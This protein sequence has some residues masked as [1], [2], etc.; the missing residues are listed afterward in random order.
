[1]YSELYLTD[2]T[3]KLDLLGANRSNNSV[4]IAV[5]KMILSRPSRESSGIFQQPYGSVVET[6]DLS[7]TGY[8]PNDVAARQQQLD[9]WLEQATN[10]FQSTAEG[11]L[12]WL[13][14]RALGETNTRYAVIY[15]G[16]IE[17]YGDIYSQP[18]SDRGICSLNDITLG[19]ERGTWLGYAPGEPVCYPLDNTYHWNSSSNAWTSMTTVTGVQSLFTTAAGTILAGNTAI[20]RSV[21]Q[22][23]GWTVPL[24]PAVANLRFWKFIQ[25][26]AGRI[27]A[28]AGMTTGAV[29]AS[30]G[31][32]FSDTD[33]ASW[34]Q[35]TNTVDF[36]G[37]AYRASDDTIIFGGDGEVR[38]IRAGGA[39]TVMSTAPTG[40]LKALEV[41]ASNDTVLGDDY[42][43]WYIPAAELSVYSGLVESVNSTDV[44]GPYLV[45]IKVKDYAIVGSATNLMISRDGGKT[46]FIYWRDWG[47]DSLSVLRNG[48]VLA[49]RAGTANVFQSFD[50]AMSWKLLS[51]LAAST[52]R[53]FCELPNQ[54]LFAGAGNA[55]Y[56]RISTQLT[57][58]YGVIEP[59]CDSKVLFSNHR[60][61]A[62]WTHILINDSSAGTF[63]TVTPDI[64]N[65]NVENQSD[66]LCFPASVGTNDAMYIGISTSVQDAGP[67]SNVYLELTE[68]N[69]TLTLAVEY[70]NGSAWT[71]LVDNSS[72]RDNTRSLKRS[73]VI[74]IKLA[75]SEQMATIAIN[76]I[77]AWWI[78]IRVTALG[79]LP[80]QLPK[81]RNVYIVQKPY[82]EMQNIPGDIPALARL[83]VKNESYSANFMGSEVVRFIAGL[84]SVDR[85]DNFTSI[86]NFS[87]I[88]NPPGIS[89]SAGVSSSFQTN[90][91][92]AAAGEFLR[93]NTSGSSAPITIG[94]LNFDA[95]MSDEYA[96]VYQVYIRLAKSGGDPDP[97]GTNCKIRLSVQS[98]SSTNVVDPGKKTEE[99]IVTN[100][101]PGLFGQY[102]SVYY[103]GKINIK[104]DR[105]MGN[106]DSGFGS[107]ILVQAI[108]VPG[109]STNYIVDLYDIILVPADEWIGFFYG[110]DW[111]ESSVYGD[112]YLDV[113]SAKLPKRTIRSMVRKI[114]TDLVC[115]SWTSDSSGIFALQPG[116][117][118][119]RLWM[120]S[121]ADHPYVFSAKLEYNPRWL[122][123]RGSD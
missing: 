15:G 34:T 27:W 32:Y 4:G 100:G 11:N 6:Y 36:F 41:I 95:D 71:A 85:G 66:A 47:I 49:G 23:V 52:V 22:G 115:S 118:K 121:L 80:A 37:V 81:F 8:S 75:T 102:A 64:V 35:H 29:V 108:T 44:T 26:G 116:G 43:V 56:R 79:T 54:F 7:I 94:T 17:S 82:V 91:T 93:L 58:S 106:E 62:N 24:N 2:G 51:T 74:A 14:A 101:P 104:P 99:V 5:R 86:I 40:K 59:K 92:L 67:F 46:W 55:V 53:A 123:L 16:R 97:N 63:T 107:R 9:R 87:Q 89:I 69:Y 70:Y 18:F 72:M 50:G 109:A 88:Q 10:Y 110:S 65:Q 57:Y 73:G 96:G 98:F 28:V 38:Y 122:A 31:I 120:L 21:D 19:L 117:G 61:E 112:E 105:F 45:A 1:M 68:V 77:T 48:V 33:G 84:R 83:M 113:D 119:Q 30:C 12:I 60:L 25:I 114:G 42:N 13:V 3:T 76:G 103:L 20:N 111:S 39:L 90:R 78:R